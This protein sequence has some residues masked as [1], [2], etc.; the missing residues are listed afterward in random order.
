MLIAAAVVDEDG[1]PV[2]EI[3]AGSQYLALC[4]GLIGLPRGRQHRARCA[5]RALPLK[6]RRSPKRLARRPSAGN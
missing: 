6:M 4:C 5:V 3:V 2:E 1:F